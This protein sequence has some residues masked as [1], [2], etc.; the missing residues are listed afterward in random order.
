MPHPAAR[1]G[2]A[3]AA[4]LL[5]AGCAH[6]ATT[7]DLVAN[8][9]AETGRCT[10]DWT[11]QTS[12]PG[13]RVTRGAASV[14]CY[15]AFEHARS[16]VATPPFPPAGRAL[17]AAPGADTAME[18][19]VD[20]AAAG[21]AID[22]GGVAFELS[23]WLGGWA[24][25][26]GQA[27]L[28]AIF[29]DADGRATRDPV[30]LAGAD[31]AARGGATALLARQA[32]GAVP[33]GTRRVALT[34]Q[35]ASGMPS[36]HDAYA[37]HVALRLRADAG[38]EGLSARAATPPES[39]VPALDHV[40]VVMMENTNF[41][42]VVHTR[43]ATSTVD[44]RMPFLAALARRGV[45]LANTWQTYHPSDQNYV[46]M[47]A[48]AT[49]RYG[50]VYFPDYHL[51]ADHL[52]D[53]LELAGKRWRA[54]VQDMGAPCNLRSTGAG[55]A[56]YSPD[57][58]PFV[59]FKDVIGLPGRCD[60]HLRDLRDFRRDLAAGDLPDFAWVAA[61]DW[62]D[63]EG[64]WSEDFDVGFSNAK[65]DR[66]LRETFA[67]LLA[68]EAWRRSRSLLVI[69]WDESG[70]WGW[71]D[72]RVP[73]VLVGSDGLLRAGSTSHAHANGYDLLRTIERGLHVGGLG[74][75]DEHA[76]L[77]GEVFADGAADDREAHAPWPAES[78]ATRGGLADTFGRSGTPAAVRVGQPLRL[79]VPAGV[80]AQAVV[81]LE[82]LGQAP[83]P[84]S[85]SHPFEADGVTALLPTA[86][87]AP[88][89]YGAWLH[90]AGAPPTLA[91]MPVL[92]LPPPAVVPGVPGV[93]IVG[94]G[95]AQAAALREGSNP[96]VRY[97][98]PTG[99]AAARG[100]IGVFPEGTPA[101][102]KTKANANRIGYWLKTPGAGL[103]AEPG[104]GEAEAYASEMR[105]GL[106]YRAQLFVEQ[107]DGTSL[108]VGW[109]A[110]FTVLPSLP[111]G[112]RD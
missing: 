18:Q 75:F 73:T 32:A 56:S 54:Y 12:V 102:R 1:I 96:I 25:G 87:L 55:R 9:D 67:P 14:L 78:A 28:T 76:R 97:C 111:G 7:P 20:V 33:A 106:A 16:A 3:F 52:G 2:R 61:N 85:A 68:S 72:N 34:L 91:P 15:A 46:A 89:A 71:P 36:F 80:D 57:D 8:G 107:A 10:D 21:R 4:A 53:L 86:G 63:G 101:V 109:A 99:T 11:A 79:V 69:T 47:V 105:P 108:A 45:L 88:G 60:A 49:F 19:V 110:P 103:E 5:C 94:A 92:L 84:R 31:A 112:G 17:F 70:G 59:Q 104:C 90:E 30:V 74:R 42:D 38:L 65:Q 44:L 98:L 62:W 37:D 64:A 83:G 43:G 50:P 82:P 13:W 29:L 40:V 27:S 51:G 23:A 93:E 39:F 81:A 26:T 77:L 95:V 48:G 100:W 22:A 6:A 58:Q 66:F 24:G 41:A 35:F